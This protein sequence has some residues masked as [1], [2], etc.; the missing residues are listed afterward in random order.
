MRINQKIED[1]EQEAL[2]L[3]R[4]YRDGVCCAVTDLTMSDPDIL[5]YPKPL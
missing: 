1:W 2:D 3:L 5:H 4:Q